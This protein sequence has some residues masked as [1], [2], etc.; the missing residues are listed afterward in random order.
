MLTVGTIKEVLTNCTK[1]AT[2]Y[3]KVTTKNL[4]R[5]IEVT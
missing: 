4:R 1:Y 3:F 2:L 5:S